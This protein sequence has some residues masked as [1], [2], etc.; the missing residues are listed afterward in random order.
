MTHRDIS[1]LP[2]TS[3]PQSCHV[4]DGPGRWTVAQPWP[5]D[6]HYK[7]QSP[8]GCTALLSGIW[9]AVTNW[10]HLSFLMCLI[11]REEPQW[12]PNILSVYLSWSKESWCINVAVTGQFNS[13]ACQRRILFWGFFLVCSVHC[14]RTVCVH[15][16]VF[17][18]PRFSSSTECIYRTTPSNPSHSEVAC[19]H[20][21]T[22]TGVRFPIMFPCDNAERAL[23][24]HT[25]IEK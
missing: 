4:S 8:T 11:V 10:S 12:M 13:P 15:V 16:S 24:Q 25:N 3:V 22:H 1:W 18:Q 5:Y 21:H 23:K 7:R 20:T 6:S 17:V 2:L 9:A 14:C 19:T